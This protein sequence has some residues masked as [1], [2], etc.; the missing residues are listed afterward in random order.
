MSYRLRNLMPRLAEVTK[1]D[2]WPAAVRQS[3]GWPPR[4]WRIKN[5]E[6]FPVDVNLS[7]REML[8][9]VPGPGCGRWIASSRRAAMCGWRWADV[10]RL[11]RGARRAQAF[12]IAADHHPGRALDRVDLRERLIG[13]ARQLALF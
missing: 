7:H 3:N 10:F 1:T 2:I 11:T 8:L 9:R 12:L 13:P 6:R 5:R 4:S